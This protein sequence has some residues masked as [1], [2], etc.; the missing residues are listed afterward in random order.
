MVE[1]Q[2]NIFG[3][4]LARGGLFTNIGTQVERMFGFLT[5]LSWDVAQYS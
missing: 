5:M 4:S 2:R 1:D 3:L